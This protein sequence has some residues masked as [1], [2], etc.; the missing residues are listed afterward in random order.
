MGR[1][2]CLWRGIEEKQSDTPPQPPFNFGHQVD[3]RNG[4]TTVKLDHGLIGRNSPAQHHQ[5]MGAV[6]GLQFRRQVAVK[7]WAFRRP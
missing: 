4:P 5:I 6:Q 3:T 1:I 7:F 2:W